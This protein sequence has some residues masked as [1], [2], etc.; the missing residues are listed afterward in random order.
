MMNQARALL[1]SVGA[2]ALVAPG[3]A[4]A[5]VAHTDVNGTNVDFVSIQ[6]TT[7]TDLTDPEPL[8]EQPVSGG[9]DNLVFNPT[10]FTATSVNGVGAGDPLFANSD[11]THSFLQLDIVATAVGF[12]IDTVTITELG[13]SFLLGPD[14]NASAFVAMSGFVR[15]VESN[16]VAIPSIDT[17]INMSA[18]FTNPP[19]GPVETWKLQQVFDITALDPQAT[20]VSIE[21]NNFLQATTDIGSTSTATIQKK[22]A[23][24]LTI[25]VPEPTSLALIGLGLFGA[26]L[27]GR[28]R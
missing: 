16:G 3:Q 11:I 2:L 14:P 5:T 23:E 18:T 25:T 26:A 4:L 10:A 6:E 22:V 15:V 27:M 12:F 1:L 13:D 7:N 9:A 28:R 24:G 20:R 8:F 21:L 17:P 19:D